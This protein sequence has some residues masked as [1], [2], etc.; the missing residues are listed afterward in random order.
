MK[1]HH[2]GIET[3]R[4]GATKRFY[5]DGF[6]FKTID[7]FTFNNERLLWMQKEELVIE[8]TETKHPFT[9]SVHFCWE[10]Y[11]IHFWIFKLRQINIAPTA[12]PYQI[13]EKDWI[14]VFFEGPSGEEI[15]LLEKKRE[16]L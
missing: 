2:A 1:W 15:E 7:S 16:H 9:S 13:E 11:D 12:G 4:L 6:G 3:A 14:T 10:V 5:E 8:F